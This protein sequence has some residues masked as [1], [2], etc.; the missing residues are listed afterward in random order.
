MTVGFFYCLHH[1]NG[2]WSRSLSDQ[3]SMRRHLYQCFVKRRMAPPK[4]SV[5][6]SK[7]QGREM[8]I[9]IVYRMP[10]L[11]GVPMI[12]CTSCGK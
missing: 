7:K 5:L 10:E 1:I 8:Y 3:S 2:L 11:K 12:E 9:A 6:G 4:F